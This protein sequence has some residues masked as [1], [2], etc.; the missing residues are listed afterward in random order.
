MPANVTGREVT[1]SEARNNF[2]EVFDQAYHEG[3][4]IVRKHSKSVAMIRL[5]QLESLW[6]L[7]AK[8]DSLKADRALAEFLNE[9]GVTLAELKKELD[10]D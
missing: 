7:E 5:D 1:A 8:L 4:V 6:Q 10:I 9:G 3:P 2:A